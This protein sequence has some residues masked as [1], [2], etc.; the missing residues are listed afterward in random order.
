MTTQIRNS[1]KGIIGVGASAGG[2]EALQALLANIPE[3]LNQYAFIVAQHVS[4]S[5]KSMLTNLLAKD[6][7]FP[8][9]EAIDGDNLEAGYIF[10]TPPDSD[11]TIQDQ[12]IVL[13]KPHSNAGPKPSVNLLFESIAENYGKFGI[14]VILSGTGTDGASGI[15]FIRKE[16]GITVAQE[17]DTA[18][19]PG[20][21]E[22]AIKTGLVDLVLPPESICEEILQEIKNPIAESKKALPMEFN[23]SD[24]THIFR[25]LTAKKGTDFS[26]YKQATVFR[27]ITKRLNFLGIHNL[28]DYIQF[29]ESN[30]TEYDEL[31]EALTI[32]VTSFYRDD[33]AFKS[34]RVQLEKLIESKKPGDSIRI[35][36]AGCSTGEEPYTIANIVSDILGNRIQDFT[37][38][39]FATD[40][41]DRAI[42][43]ARKAVYEGNVK[44]NREVSRIHPVRNEINSSFEI[45]KN[46]RSM[47]I[48]TKHDISKN[49]PFLNLDLIICRNLLIYF[50]LPLQQQIIPLFHYALKPNGIL[51]L[52]KSENIG[53]YSN[54]FSAI[55]T[56]NRIFQRRDG[57]ATR[58][59]RLNPFQSQANTIHLIGA[60]EAISKEQ[61]SKEVVKE[62]IFQAFDKPYI[63]VKE[64]LDIILL[65]GNTS[66]F[67][68]IPEGVM[69]SNLMTLIHEDLRTGIRFFLSKTQ[70]EKQKTES[71]TFSLKNK[72]ISYNVSFLMIPS[73]DSQ[74]NIENIL[75]IFDVKEAKVKSRKRKMTQDSNALQ[76]RIEELEKEL[77][78][79]KDYV[80]YYIEDLER[81]N[82]ELQSLNEE[83]QSSNEEMQSSNEELETSI[84]ELQAANEE[85]Q[86]AYSELKMVNEDLERK[87]KLLEFRESAERAILNSSL[88]AFVLT[89]HS[90]KI[91][92]VNEIAQTAFQKMFNYK[93]KISDSILDYLVQMIPDFNDLGMIRLSQGEVLR[94]EAILPEKN[95]EKKVINY[96]ITPILDSKNAIS[97]ISFSFVDITEM[98]E[99]ER[100]LF[101]TENLAKSVF[102]AVH[103]GI[104][105]LDKEGNFVLINTAFARMFGYSK[106]E[107]VGQN[108]SI[109]FLQESG[110]DLRTLFKGLIL[111]NHGISPEWKGKRKN[112]EILDVFLTTELLIQ[113][114]GQ[115][116]IVMSI[117]DITEKMRSQ[118]LLNETQSAAH[119]GGWEFDFIEDRFMLTAETAKLLN[120]SDTGHID[121]QTLVSLFSK[122]ERERF[123]KEFQSAIENKSEFELV[124]EVERS[125]G[126]NS[127][128][129]VIGKPLMMKERILKMYGFFQDISERIFHES[130]I[131]KT[132]ELL[133]QTNQIAK[134]GGWE[135]NFLDNSI[136]FTSIAREIHEI[137]DS[138]VLTTESC[139]NFYKE[140]IYRE[141]ATRCFQNLVEFGMPCDE[142][143]LIVTATGKER[144]VRITG[145]AIKKNG[146]VVGAFGS[147]QD[148][149]EKRMSSESIRISKERYDLLIK[150]TQDAIWDWDMREG[151]LFMG[152]GYRT[153]F[154][155]NDLDDLSKNFETWED[156][157]HPDDRPYVHEELLHLLSSNDLNLLL[158]E[159]RMKRADGTFAIVSDKSFLIRDAEGNPFRLVG[160]I[161][162]ITKQK[163]EEEQL[164]L[165]E[166]VIKN[167]NDIIVITEAE[168]V[169]KPGPRIV[170]ANNAFYNFTGYTPEEVIGKTPRILQGEKTDRNELKRIGSAMRTWTYCEAE[171]INYK[172]NGEE[173]WNHFSL[174]PLANESGLFTHWIAIERDVTA[175]KKQ[176]EE[177]E[178]LI[179]ELTVSNIDLKQFAYIT[180]HNLRAPL[181][182]LTGALELIDD[183]EISDPLL[184][185]LID[186][187]RSS[188]NLLNQTVN[189]LI[190]IL[191]IKDSTNVEKE[192]LSFSASFENVF[193]QTSFLIHESKLTINSD[194]S[195]CDQIRFNKAYLESI[196]M[197]LLT[198]AIKYKSNDRLPELNIKSY[199]LNDKIVLEFADNGL[200]IDLVRNKGRIFGL[201]QRFHNAADGKGLGLYLVKSQVEALGGKIEV[202]SQVNTGTVFRIYFK[203]SI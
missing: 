158:L 33:K 92:S 45:P 180:S 17:P 88:Q 32:G 137:E 183:I 74:S 21:P 165:F 44:T 161:Q 41:N 34:L 97:I 171:V 87:D 141:K 84:E 64:N 35:W 72:N 91:L 90:L 75:I 153:L 1:A 147:I 106:E 30:P 23:L 130:E 152:E 179:Q 105:I 167:A 43:A 175:K 195:L 134:V 47:V 178:N 76:E 54:L 66:T 112:D 177:R 13:S 40:I 20:M 181:S 6:A 154:G 200:G 120:L 103:I 197:N 52:G 25:M 19:F 190:R 186:G 11:L 149:H 123:T 65:H 89:D 69:N 49:P 51:F 46:L 3:E 38:Q 107:I 53:N 162:D 203:G 113:D 114:D 58:P 116:Y 100:N 127:Y 166:S 157:I 188:T 128:Y 110:N 131:Q 14:G 148:I 79:S 39:I 169:A 9:K 202:D 126:Y 36:S 172:K 26:E 159:Y 135:I 99:T 144:W 5:H 109:T 77:K 124:L 117:R 163:K 193:K 129:R 184:K 155:Y 78:L 18:K 68:T 63:L 70:K 29:L 132:K 93:P 189:D 42:V 61:L 7:S 138:E 104:S 102:E 174:I 62:Q 146:L 187:F 27:R 59:L 2:L 83:I 4:P 60:K 150:A 108:F 111:G 12:S 145:R 156:V 121:I 81:A 50:D 96:N 67:L 201:Y 80:K 57:R 15:S 140:G 196:F 37:V 119:V 198:N 55:D 192:I 71:E 143:L 125:L 139:L 48:F 151:T 191:I 31:F 115:R 86:I 28:S 160:A 122:S 73:L 118:N 8:V 182:N 94:G 173:Y 82:V 95:N 22:A 136:T 142:E 170:Y 168:P 10:I 98:R 56:Q 194:F 185:Q 101:R 176:E 199:F 16:G 24:L 85:I 164:R 133:E